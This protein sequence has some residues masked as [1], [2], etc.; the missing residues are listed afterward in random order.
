[1]LTKLS[2]ELKSTS[3]EL[4]ELVQQK[5]GGTAFSVAYN[6]IRQKVLEVQ[7]ERRTKRVMLG[8][9]HPEQAARRKEKKLKL[10]KES[11]KRR[12]HS[13]VDSRSGKRRRKED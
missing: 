5:V 13:F 10:K 2:E 3:I 7:R 12:T 8:T 11:K 4:R 1:V 9:Q 6:T